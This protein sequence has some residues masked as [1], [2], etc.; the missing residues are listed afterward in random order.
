MFC[1]VFR[2]QVWGLQGW[3]G[4]GVVEATGVWFRLYGVGIV[5]S[6]VDGGNLA[7]PNIFAP[8]TLIMTFWI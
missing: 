6:V 2:F 4:G 8:T 5:G 1:S 7:H 3:E